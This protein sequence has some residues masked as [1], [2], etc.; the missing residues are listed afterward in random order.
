MVY[1]RLFYMVVTNKSLPKWKSGSG[2]WG[3][4]E[5][6]VLVFCQRRNSKILRRASRVKNSVRTI[7]SPISNLIQAVPFAFDLSPKW[8][9]VPGMPTLN[10]QRDEATYFGTYT[11]ASVG[12]QECSG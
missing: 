11:Y 9:S 6:A 7:G 2:G 1:L 8:D 3:S 5:E 4:E 12:L 10:N